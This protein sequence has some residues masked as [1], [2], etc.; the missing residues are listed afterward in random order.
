MHIGRRNDIF[1]TQTSFSHLNDEPTYWPRPSSTTPVLGVDP[2]AAQASQGGPSNLG[3]DDGFESPTGPSSSNT[4]STDW[5]EL[6]EDPEVA[7]LVE[8]QLEPES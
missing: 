3:L 6:L 7:W 2:Q 1:T 4:A 5:T 8:E